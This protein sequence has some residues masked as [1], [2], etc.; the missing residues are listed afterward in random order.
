[1]GQTAGAK[2]LAL[3]M[4]TV[5]TTAAVFEEWCY[6]HINGYLGAKESSQPIQGT[7]QAPQGSNVLEEV[8]RMLLRNFEETGKKTEG[9]VGNAEKNED[10][11]VKPYTQYEIAKLIGYC[12]EV[13]PALLPE[14]WKLV[15][16][17][18]E[19]DDHCMNLHRKML[20]WSKS[21]FLR[22]KRLRIW[23]R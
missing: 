22:K 4:A 12:N 8:V 18:K 5:V 2:A 23:L 16:T 6:N 10:K 13:D 3:S 7:Q 17:T 21:I 14:F 15:K 1:V 9:M 11:K 20:E 19:T